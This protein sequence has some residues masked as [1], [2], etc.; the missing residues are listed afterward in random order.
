MTASVP[1]SPPAPDV[2][3]TRASWVVLLLFLPP[4]L[5]GCGSSDEQAKGPMSRGVKNDAKGKADGERTEAAARIVDN[6]FLRADANPSSTFSI[7]VDTASYSNVRRFL[8]QEG[9][10]PPAD[11]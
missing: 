1:P 5:A 9:R 3:R 7:A 6:T 11:A 2:G 10:L 4:M 8:L